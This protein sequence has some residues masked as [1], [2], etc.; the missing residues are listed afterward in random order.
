V[1]LF[2]QVVKKKAEESTTNTNI[3]TEV[4]QNLGVISANYTPSSLSSVSSSRVG[5]LSTDPCAGVTDFAV[6]QSNLI[7]EYLRIGKDSVDTIS[8]LASQLGTALGQVPDG[9]SGTSSDG[10]VSWN[11][12]SEKVWSLISRNTSNAT[13]A[14]FSVNNGVYSL[15]IDNN[16]SE[17]T[18]LDHQIEA[19]ITYNS[20][21]NWSV[22]VYFG[23]GVCSSL[24][25]TDP[26][27]AHIKISKSNGLWSGKAMLYAPRWQ[28]PGASVPTCATTAG[29]NDIAMYTD[30][31]GNDT[32][33]KAAL[34]MIH[35][36]ESNISNIT[37]VN[38]SLPQFCTQFASACGGSPGQ[39]PA[40]FL[41]SYQNNWCTTGVGTS[42]TWNDNCTT[43]TAVSGASYSSSTNWVSPSALKIYSVAMPTGL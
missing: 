3:S 25:P 10:K 38:Y 21:D 19:M 24:K 30:F 35:S 37:D 11:K 7:R 16:N 20:S 13:V 26:S 18:P 31:V 4:V 9:N 15:K 39:V 40:G 23:N 33:T 1:E 14:Y 22:D 2:L 5:A 17:D 27:K 29:A 12:T 43:N 34:Y 8:S 36:T 42:P 28:T 32:S 41:A 6:C